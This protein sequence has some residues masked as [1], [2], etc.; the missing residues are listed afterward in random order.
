MYLEAKE[1][2]R[3]YKLLYDKL[4]CD[5]TEAIFK[6]LD[7]KTERSVEGAI[8][9][10]ATKEDISNVRKEIGENKGDMIKWMLI[11]WIGQI[12]A[13]LTFALLFLKK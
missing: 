5:T 3:L 10:L 8:K 9:T 7:S 6:C 13:T 1:T 11:F 4:G 2:A 12:G